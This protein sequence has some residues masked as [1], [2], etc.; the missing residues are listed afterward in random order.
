MD[1][2]AYQ[3]DSNATSQLPP[4]ASASPPT[5]GNTSVVVPVLNSEGTLEP[6]VRRLL[7]LDQ[8]RG[9]AEIVLVDD[10]STDASWARILELQARHPRI[11]AFRLAR[12]YGQHNAL[13]VG[14]RAAKS[15]YIATIDDDLQNPPEE[16][17]RL[18][19]ALSQGFAVVYGTPV[20]QQ[21]GILRNFASKITKLALSR[22]MGAETARSV[23]AFR[24]FRTQLRGAFETFNGPYVSIDVLLTWGTSS[25]HS[26]PV[27]CDERRI[28]QSQYTFRKLFTH[29]MNMMTGFTTWPLRI[30]SLTGFAFAGFGV[31]VLAWVLG[32]Y[33][34][35]GTAVSGFP[36][37]ASIIAIFSGAQLF[38]LGILGEYLARIHF[39]LMDRPSYFV[40]TFSNRDDGAEG[41]A[42]SRS[43]GPRQGE[44][45]EGKRNPD[46]SLR[47]SGVEKATVNEVNGLER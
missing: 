23:S 35:E 4:G 24:V 21:H 29:A 12:N 22:T 26:I 13:L 46:R 1:V 27:R 19:T 25:F 39:R 45:D 43:M 5:I 47:R 18:L 40:Q 37:L 36:F 9:P 11:L 32:R 28:G 3:T 33:A 38:S 30:A 16:I 31:M 44:D 7:D 6:L 2:T 34:V 14:I 10:G 20:S 42:P 41:A 8:G 17:E 15:T